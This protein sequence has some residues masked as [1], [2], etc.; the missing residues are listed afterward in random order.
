MD[1]KACT[2]LASKFLSA[3]KSRF[4]ERVFECIDVATIDRFCVALRFRGEWIFSSVS[5]R[6]R[7]LGL[8]RRDFLGK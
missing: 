6:A 7:F 2:A 5:S 4:A 3:S 1:A 8:D